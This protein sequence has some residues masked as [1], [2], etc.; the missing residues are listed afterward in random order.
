MLVPLIL[1]KWQ[2]QS[3]CRGGPNSRQLQHSAF[4]TRSQRGP[5]NTALDGPLQHDRDVFW[6]RKTAKLMQLRLRNPEFTLI[7]GSSP[8]VPVTSSHLVNT[9]VFETS[10]LLS[11]NPDD[12]TLTSSGLFT[13]TWQKAWFNCWTGWVVLLHEYMSRLHYF[14][15]RW[16]K[17]P[18]SSKVAANNDSIS[19]LSFFFF[20][21][22]QLLDLVYK[23]K[24]CVFRLHLFWSDDISTSTQTW[25]LNPQHHFQASAPLGVHSFSTK[26]PVTTLEQGTG[27]EL[28]LVPG[29]CTAAAHCS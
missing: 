23:N 27:L 21:F 29:C 18:S 15:D 24:W 19:W 7:Y 17:E 2:W 22:K 10:Y 11:D 20:F 5:Q 25:G 12:I 14:T 3:Q 16:S 9:Q 28:K 4:S 26:S 8:K 1:C 6:N 13:W